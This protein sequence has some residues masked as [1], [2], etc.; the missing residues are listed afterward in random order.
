MPSGPIEAAEAFVVERFPDARAAIVAGSVIRGE[1]TATSDL[2]LVLVVDHE[3]APFRASYRYR[4]WPIEAFVHTDRSYERYFDVERGRPSLAVMIDEGVVLRNVDRAA[5]RARE[6]ARAAL[7]AGPAP[8]SEE[9][10]EDWR[11]SLTDLLDDFLG[12]E[13]RDEGI[14]IANRLAVEAA[15]LLLL[16]H[17]QWHGDGKWVPRALTRYNPEI[18]QRLTEALDVYYRFDDK[19]PLVVFAE[20][21]LN[22]AGGRLFEGYY[23][24]G[25]R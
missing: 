18:S 15:D 12:G 25:T 24:A 21:V 2:D 22:E 3:D 11:Y 10:L 19:A 16:L 5:D 8:L 23:R 13:R 6:A 17:R 7:D 9:A 14:F 1:G 4:N 20:E